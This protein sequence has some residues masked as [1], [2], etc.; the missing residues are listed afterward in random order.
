AEKFEKRS[1][2]TWTPKELSFLTNRAQAD[3][4]PLYQAMNW[5]KA[6]FEKLLGTH[7]AIESFRTGLGPYDGVLSDPALVKS[8]LEKPFSPSSLEEL[9]QCPFQYFASHVLKIPVE[10]D[11]APEGEMTP[12]GLTTFPQD[13]RALLYRLPRHV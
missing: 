7:E 1:P 9:A 11:L 4:R 2:Q 12:Q 10:E 5:D 3:P 6:G 13:A 8:T